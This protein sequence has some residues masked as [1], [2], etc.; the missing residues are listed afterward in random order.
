MRKIGVRQ[1]AKLA[2]V[3]PGTV[4]RALHGRKGISD[5]TRKRILAIAQSTG[6]EP[7]LAARALSA[8]RVPIRIGVCI[9][10][11]IHHYFS[12]LLAGILTE[13]RRLE[14]L[15]VQVI[16]NP[17]KRLG[18][19]ECEKVA[20]LLRNEVHA[21]LIAPGDPTKLTPL[22]NQAEKENV[23]VVCVDTDAPASHR[24]TLVSVN[25]EIAG[26]LAAELMSS[27]VAPQSEVAIV[28]GM[29]ETQDHAKK[30]KGFSDLYPQLSQGGRVVEVVEAHEDE[31]QAFQKCFVLLRQCRSLAGFYVNTVNCL[32]VCRAICAQGCSGK[33]ALI[34]TDLYSGMIPYFEK[35][36][37]RA[38]IHGRP[39]IQGELAMRLVVDHLANHRHL[40]LFYYLAPHIV[41]KSNLYMYREVRNPDGSVGIANASQ[42]QAP[43]WLGIPERATDDSRGEVD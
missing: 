42:V 17:V 35:G 36:T 25:A 14:R 32:P 10:R 16:Y 6:Y 27:F 31:E 38:S 4:D 1:I 8:G 15:G 33:T 23:R 40:P 13:A 9:P 34:T 20:E 43:D 41:M 12:Q 2:N 18:V 11:E 5:G 24:S 21:V 26:K 3:S 29:L 19:E 28:T 37:I 39:F 7:D 30:T 22:I